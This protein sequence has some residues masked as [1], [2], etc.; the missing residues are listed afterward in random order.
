MVQ[1]KS[2]SKTGTFVTMEIRVAYSFL[3]VFCVC[4]CVCLRS[5]IISLGQRKTKQNNKNNKFLQIGIAKDTQC[6]NLLHILMNS[7][8]HI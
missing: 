8:F 5:G 1:F 7:T 4:V 6:T 3:F 2:V